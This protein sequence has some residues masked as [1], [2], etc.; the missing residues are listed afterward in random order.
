MTTLPTTNVE[1]A[2]AVFQ[3]PIDRRQH[4]YRDIT[5]GCI[6]DHSQGGGM[7]DVSIVR[8][9]I[10]LGMPPEELQGLDHTMLE[11]LGLKAE[12]WDG[13]W[14][15]GH[16]YDHDIDVTLRDYSDAALAWLNCDEDGTRC[17]PDLAQTHHYEVDDNCLWL[18]PDEEGEQR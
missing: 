3:F 7:L 17:R 13:Q 18:L 16:A 4:S 8:V 15:A 9:A 14:L 2:D 11:V 12:W 10:A 1:L 6:I 5:P